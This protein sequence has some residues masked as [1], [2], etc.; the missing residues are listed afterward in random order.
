MS[1]GEEWQRYRR[2]A[3]RTLKDFGFGRAG[4]ESIIQ[5]EANIL[6]K[7][8]RANTKNDHM[9]I[10]TLFSV[11]VVNVL[12]QMVLSKRFDTEKD[13]FIVDWINKMNCLAT[14]NRFFSILNAQ[15]GGNISRIFRTE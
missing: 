6:C 15:I 1:E 11:P 9:F 4:C 5:D 8:M 3:L 13:P 7:Q 2:F 14:G 12:W 10:S